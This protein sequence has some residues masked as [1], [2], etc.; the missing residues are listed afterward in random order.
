MMESLSTMKGEILRATLGNEPG[1]KHSSIMR[2]RNQ[3]NRMS[4]VRIRTLLSM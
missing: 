4:T 2:E 1:T 3:F